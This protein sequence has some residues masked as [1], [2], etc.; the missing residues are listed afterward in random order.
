MVFVFSFLVGL[1]FV[2]ITLIKKCFKQKLLRIKFPIKSSM[3]AYLYLPQEWSR[4]FQRWCCDFIRNSVW[5]W[6]ILHNS[7]LLFIF[8]LPLRL[9][10]TDQDSTSHDFWVDVHFLIRATLQDYSLRS[11]EWSK[12]FSPISLHYNYI[13]TG[14]FLKPL[15]PLIGEIKICVYLIFCKKFNYA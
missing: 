13:K 6:I 15:P 11:L 9:I 10:F 14:K 12:S 8:R 7:S 4:G 2:T 5:K 1:G 3:E